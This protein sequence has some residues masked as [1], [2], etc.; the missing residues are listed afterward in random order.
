MENNPRN[1]S[2]KKPFRKP[3][4]DDAARFGRYM[5]AGFQLVGPIIV[6]VLIGMF[7]D[8]KL[9]MTTPFFTLGFATLFLGVGL[10]L[11]IKQF[12]K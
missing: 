2:G 9:S 12:S 11:F 7:I 1:S 6:G 8:K 3:S 10:Y 4:G 5:G